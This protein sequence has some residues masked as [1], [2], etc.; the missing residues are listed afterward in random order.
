M[1]A[2][3]RLFER[4]RASKKIESLRAAAD[5]LGVSKQG[6]TD[7]KNGHNAKAH[8]IERM[9][10]DLGEDPV[11]VI[12]EA[13]TEAE[14]DADAKRALQR[15]AKRFRGTLA[16]T[17]L[18]LVPLLSAGPVSAHSASTGYSLCELSGRTGCGLGIF[19]ARHPLCDP[20]FLGRSP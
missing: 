10:K 15:L 20:T 12:I 2:T 4:W 3:F 11:P 7:W 14:K 16:A 5:E 19:T 13:L 6:P 17:A 8:V 1:T 9:A 18:A